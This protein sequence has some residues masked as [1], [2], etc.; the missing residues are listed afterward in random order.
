MVAEQMASIRRGF[1]M[2]GT[3]A[4]DLDEEWASCQDTVVKT[5]AP[6]GDAEKVKW[7]EYA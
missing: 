5:G 2:C 3:F 1:S 7:M 6:I 4:R